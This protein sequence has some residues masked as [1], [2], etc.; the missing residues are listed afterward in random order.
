[1]ENTEANASYLVK[2]Q[3]ASATKF[4][5][6]TFCSSTVG[7]CKRMGIAQIGLMLPWIR[8]WREIRIKLQA[9]RSE[10]PSFWQAVFLESKVNG[11]SYYGDILPSHAWSWPKK[12]YLQLRLQTLKQSR[13]FLTNVP[14]QA[15]MSG[16]QRKLR[17]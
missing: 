12:T 13:H 9:T 3:E 2:F 4:S 7:R 5:F 8:I 15:H 11:A 1:M 16:P 6:R 14:P 17:S 10:K